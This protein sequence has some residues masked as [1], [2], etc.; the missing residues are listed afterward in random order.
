MRVDSD[1]IE[2]EEYFEQEVNGRTNSPITYSDNVNSE[3][4]ISQFLSIP[5][6]PDNDIQAEVKKNSAIPTGD[7]LLNDE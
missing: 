3:D 4:Y 2:I 1:S 7:C 6:L 5:S